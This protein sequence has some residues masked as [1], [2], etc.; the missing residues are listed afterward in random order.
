[1]D[2]A[3]GKRLLLATHAGGVGR[4][5]RV[6]CLATGAIFAAFGASKFTNHA[7]E[8]H[9]FRTYGLPSPDAFVY[10]IGVIETAG[11][12]LL[13]IGLATRLAALVLSGDMVGAIA[14]AGVK[15]GGVLNL[16]LAPAL[17]TTMLFLLWAGSG[18]VALD[19]RLLGN[20][21]RARAAARG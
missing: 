11:G 20:R 17:L 6:L 13:I 4:A 7:S 10:F 2:L 21:D 19:Q 3:R 8:V 12:I 15:E 5:A 1:M 14:I 18:P 16:G 9:S